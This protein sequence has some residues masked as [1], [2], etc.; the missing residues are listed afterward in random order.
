[1]FWR[2]FI[3]ENSV[4]DEYRK[5]CAYFHHRPGGDGCYTIVEKQNKTCFATY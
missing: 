5:K 3:A 1:M 4:M 2:T